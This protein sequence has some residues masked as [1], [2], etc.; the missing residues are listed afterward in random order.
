MKFK[1][2]FILL[3][4]LSLR[5]YSQVDLVNTDQID[6]I[7]NG[8]VYVT[9]KDTGSAIAKQY[10]D[11]YRKY[12]TI[13]KIQFIND[14]DI[15][16]HLSP[17]SIFLTMNYYNPTNYYTVYYPKYIAPGA[18]YNN[19]QAGRDMPSIATH[20]SATYK[21]TS[22]FLYLA[23]WDCNENYFKKKHAAEPS[24]KD[25][26]YIAKII[27]YP[28]Y[29]TLVAP[30][31]IYNY[32]YDWGGHIRNWGPGMLKNY[33]QSLVS[34]INS[35]KTN[36]VE[37]DEIDNKTELA[38]LTSGTLYIPDYTMIE[39]NPPDGNET[40]RH[41]E[42]ELLGSYTYSYKIITTQE[43]NDKILNSNQPFYYLRYVKDCAN[44]IVQVVNAQTGEVIY[45]DYTK[46]SYNIKSKDIKAISDA[47]KHSA[48]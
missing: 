11:V 32:N 2:A 46:I 43:L 37:K 41:T 5:A 4:F 20:T 21:V 44:K 13:S 27:L 18:A 25:I 40:L 12:W 3:L 1:P 30:D 42:S 7:K 16:R 22:S 31:S 48:K 28:D 26:K 36:E 34:Y 19:T 8:T 35:G 9:F 45:S 6:R 23:L 10:I 15:D 29:Q 33:I 24:D 17:G 38:N 47:I 14:T 39:Y